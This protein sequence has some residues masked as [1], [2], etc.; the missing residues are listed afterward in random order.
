[1]LPVELSDL[2]EL[3]A[4]LVM[5]PGSTTDGQQVDARLLNSTNL[6]FFVSTLRA[7]RSKDS[8]IHT[9]HGQHSIHAL[10]SVSIP[11]PLDNVAL[12]SARAPRHPPRHPIILRRPH[13]RPANAMLPL[14]PRCYRHRSIPACPSRSG[15]I[16]TTAAEYNTYGSAHRCEVVFA[17][18]HGVHCEVCEGRQC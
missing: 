1:M 17:C 18:V 9:H 7:A 16:H 13:P 3:D 10:H 5:G 15:R 6:F 2:T 4:Y 12:Q 14:A 11:S 8:H